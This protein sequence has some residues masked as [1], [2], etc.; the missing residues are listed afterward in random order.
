MSFYSR[1]N[2]YGN[3]NYSPRSNSNSY[4]EG[5]PGAK[6]RKFRPGK[7]N[8][9]GNIESLF[10]EPVAPPPVRSPSVSSRQGGGGRDNPFRSRAAYG[11]RQ[12]NQYA[13]FVNAHYA[14]PT[15][16][17]DNYYKSCQSWQEKHQLAY[18]RSRC[19]AL[20][21]E[22]Q[23]LFEQISSLIEENC[24]FAEVMEA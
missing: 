17:W 5:G 8:Q 22:N 14:E 16:Y 10:R 12:D 23:M 1:G 20:E 4:S 9:T 24:I 2:S 19:L 13:D 11:G 18:Y 21:F 7:K 3:N 15:W 6:R